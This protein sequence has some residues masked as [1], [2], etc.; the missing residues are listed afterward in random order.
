MVILRVQKTGTANVEGTGERMAQTE[1]V[2]RILTQN[3]GRDPERLQRKYAAMRRDPFTFL[4]GTCHLFYADWPQTSP[5]NDAPVTWI[6]GDLHFENFGSYKGDNRQTYFDMNDFDEAMLAPCT[7]DVARF[8]TSVL[9]GAHTLKVRPPTALA[10]CEVFVAAYT[11]ALADGKARWVERDTARGM[12]KDL[13][14]ALRRR[15]RGVFLDSRTERRGRK[16]T[17]RLDGRRAFPVTDTDRGKIEAFMMRY[18]AAQP[19]PA[20]FRVLDVARRIAGTGSLG[21]ERYV[22][23]VRGRSSPNENFLLDLKC[24]P[25]SALAPYVPC[26]Q[27]AWPHEAA[28]VVTIQRRVQA[29]AP[30]FL[31]AV[32]I[33]DRSYVLRELLPTQDRLVLA[34]WHGKIRRLAHV[35][36]VMGQLVAW[37]QLRSG[38]LQGSATLDTLMGFAHQPGWQQPL[39]AYALRYSAHV[40]QEWQQF[41]EAFDKGVLRA[42][43]SQERDEVAR[44]QGNTRP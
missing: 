22:I 30:A 25:T 42:Q 4:R 20:F 41:C 21:L 27:P 35:M 32:T 18:A 40:V 34:H 10:L 11:A 6:C 2:Q 43:G 8:L 13:L 19:N 39:L 36:D 16:R 17:L 26:P 28:R 1:S 44:A 29:I 3:Q 9:V 37:G 7:W 14:E 15:H 33:G 24:E 38:G 23:L 5:L 12:V 31:Q